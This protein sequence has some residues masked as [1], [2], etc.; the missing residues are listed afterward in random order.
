MIDIWSSAKT[1]IRPVKWQTKGEAELTVVALFLNT[2]VKGRNK[3]RKK[4]KLKN[5]NQTASNC[6]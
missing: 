6:F 4:K 1:R 3:K 5:P 2:D